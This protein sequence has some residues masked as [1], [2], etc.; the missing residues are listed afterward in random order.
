MVFTKYFN[1][2]H[3]EELVYDDLGCLQ[4]NYQTIRL[5]PDGDDDG[6]TSDSENVNLNLDEQILISIN[7]NSVEQSGTSYKYSYR[8]NMSYETGHYTNVAYGDVVFSCYK[9]E[10]GVTQIQDIIVNGEP[11]DCLHDKYNDCFD[12][13]PLEYMDIL[14]HNASYHVPDTNPEFD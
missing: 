1:I 5:I 6:Y 12:I 8:V 10:N 11:N 7:L 13:Y 3:P 9:D 4:A 2:E 14:T